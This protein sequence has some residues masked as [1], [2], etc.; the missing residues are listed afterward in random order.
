MRT[1]LGA[2]CDNST[3][4]AALGR[5]FRDL[6]L[7]RAATSEGLSANQPPA[8]AA[9]SLFCKG[10]GGAGREV[11]GG[12]LTLDPCARKPAGILCGSDWFSVR[13]RLKLWMTIEGVKGPSAISV[14]FL[15]EDALDW[16]R[17]SAVWTS[18][19]QRELKFSFDK[20]HSAAH[21]I[22]EV[23][24]EK[25]KFSCGGHFGRGSASTSINGT[26]NTELLP[27]ERS[28]WLIQ[29]I[30][31]HNRAQ[32]DELFRIF[33]AAIKREFKPTELPEAEGRC[34]KDRLNI[35]DFLHGDPADM[36]FTAPQLHI[37]KEEEKCRP[38]PKHFDGGRGLI[39][40]AIALWSNR[41][42]RIWRKDGTIAEMRTKS[43]HCYLANFIGCEHQVVHEADSEPEDVAHTEH[44]GRFQALLFV[45]CA[46]FRHNRCANACFLWN[47]GLDG[48][49]CDALNRGYMKWAA[50]HQIELPNRADLEA[51]AKDQERDKVGVQRRKKM[52]A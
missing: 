42:I 26:D 3:G 36:L 22:E 9:T 38:M 46:T 10:L 6:P 47:E 1:A 8:N 34:A 50:S 51:A 13:P 2:H 43:G 25:V 49:L 17:G 40:L 52:R 20:K 29:W 14:A 44:L 18:E 37:Q 30:V 31:D 48:R 19:R 21:A 5:C 27:C 23:D 15:H 12:L 35:K 11:L 28:R 16:L 45:R 4:D 7:F 33:R 41:L 24:G 39:V 32:F